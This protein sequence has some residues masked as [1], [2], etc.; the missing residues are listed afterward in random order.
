MQESNQHWSSCHVLFHVGTDVRC[1]RWHLVGF[2]SYY[3]YSNCYYYYFHDSNSKNNNDNYYSS[4][5]FQSNVV[6]FTIVVVHQQ[7]PFLSWSRCQGCPR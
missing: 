2:F 6:I 4:G 1:W 5:P 7:H 3:K